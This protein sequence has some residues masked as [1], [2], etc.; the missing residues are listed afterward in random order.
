[1]QAYCVSFGFFCEAK[2]KTKKTAFEKPL[3]FFAFQKKVNFISQRKFCFLCKPP[4]FS[5][6]AP[7]F[8][9]PGF[10]GWLYQPKKPGP[11]KKRSSL[12]SPA[13]IGGGGGVLLTAFF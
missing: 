1:M 3:G 4:G 5:E 10:F 13:W 6:R 12:V 2:R 7:G 11:K 8:F 9:G